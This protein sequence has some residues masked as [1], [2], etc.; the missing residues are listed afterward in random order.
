MPG[1]RQQ[2]CKCDLR[3]SADGADRHGWTI[4][5]GERAMSDD[6]WLPETAPP[7]SMPIAM[8]D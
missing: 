7:K 8:I 4:T 3:T 1:L 2:R 5:K 6:E